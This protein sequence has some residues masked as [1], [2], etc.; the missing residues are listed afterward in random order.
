MTINIITKFNDFTPFSPALNLKKSAFNLSPINNIE[1]NNKL[2][3]ELQQ[4]ISFSPQY[5]NKSN[6]NKILKEEND[7][8][9][10]KEI[11]NEQY[12]IHSKSL[13]KKKIKKNYN[14][15]NI[16]IQ[17]NNDSSADNNCEEKKCSNKKDISEFDKNKKKDI[18]N[19]NSF[20]ELK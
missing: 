16:N 5:K 3:T 6:I 15:I 14:N 1:D 13:Y 19:K 20:T 12:K 9:D 17:N 7:N 8:I 10:N 4:K 11:N 2:N 18:N